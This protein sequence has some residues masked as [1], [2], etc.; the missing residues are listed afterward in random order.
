M[1]NL[2]VQFQVSFK[3]I[4]SLLHF[5]MSLHLCPLPRPWGSS[6]PQQLRRS[7]EAFSLHLHI[8]RADPTPRPAVCVGLSLLFTG[9]DSIKPL[10]AVVS[11]STAWT[12]VSDSFFV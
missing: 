6:S 10:F 3:A 2:Q 5:Q 7:I 8:T 1:C 12:C 9:T 11:T 4:S